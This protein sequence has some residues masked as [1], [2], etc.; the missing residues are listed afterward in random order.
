MVNAAAQY[1]RAL[2][3]ELRCSSSASKRL[4]VGFNRT[5]SAYLEEHSS[6]N[7]DDL[8]A[9]FGPPEAMAEALMAE[10]TAQEHAMYCKRTLAGKILICIMV[11][12][13]AFFTLYIWFF[14]NVGL[15]ST[16]ELTDIPVN[17]S[18]TYN[19]VSEDDS[20]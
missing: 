18:E 16:N 14:K 13:L 11:V 6:P 2:K 15:T 17:W 5:L 10:V 4:M 9:A 1:R 3:K 8:I 19:I 20:K 7:T 12:I